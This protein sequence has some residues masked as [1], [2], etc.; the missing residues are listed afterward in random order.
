LGRFA[1]AGRARGGEGLGRG[2]GDCALSVRAAAVGYVVEAAGRSFLIGVG[3]GP[4]TVLA[5]LDGEK[6]KSAAAATAP[7][8]RFA[9]VLA[10]ALGRQPK[11][12]PPTAASEERA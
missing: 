1:A 10:R 9:E 5:E 12:A 4:M 8:P 11:S 7:G 2:A 3:E 6:L